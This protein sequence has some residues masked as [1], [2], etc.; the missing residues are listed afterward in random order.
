MRKSTRSGSFSNSPPRLSANSCVGTAIVSSISSQ[1]LSKT[2]AEQR[3]SLRRR[4]PIASNASEKILGQSRRRE[5]LTATGICQSILNTILRRV[6]NPAANGIPLGADGA[7]EIDHARTI[8]GSPAGSLCA[9]PIP[10]NR[11]GGSRSGR[12]WLI[13]IHRG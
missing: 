13:R 9:R 5:F 8:G 3:K 7:F 10:E 12:L 2:D 1:V 11:N 6:L 4:V